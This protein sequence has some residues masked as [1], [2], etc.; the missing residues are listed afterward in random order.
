MEVRVNPPF[1]HEKSLEVDDLADVILEELFGEVPDCEC[2]LDGPGTWVEHFMDVV[3]IK[4]NEIL[5]KSSLT[6]IV[7][8]AVLIY[9]LAVAAVRFDQCWNAPAHPL[10]KADLMREFFE[11]ME[12]SDPAAR[13]LSEQLRMTPFRAKALLEAKKYVD[14]D[15]LTVDFEKWISET[16]DKEFVMFVNNI[17]KN[18]DA[19]GSGTNI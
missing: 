4:T 6:Y 19:D 11:E 12:V 9:A 3:L 14:P 13:A 15:Y 17:V 18:A 10:Y 16:E 8:R 5:G 7:D 2:F 1:M